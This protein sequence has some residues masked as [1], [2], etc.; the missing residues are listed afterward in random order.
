LEERGLMARRA[1]EARRSRSHSARPAMIHARK[2][3]LG[4]WSQHPTM[5]ATT[6]RMWKAMKSSYAA[7]RRAANDD[8]R[9]RRRGSHATSPVTNL[10]LGRKPL[11]RYP[12]E[13]MVAVRTHTLPA[14]RWSPLSAWVDTPVSA[15]R[16]ELRAASPITRGSWAN[17]ACPIGLR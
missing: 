1:R 12:A 7:R 14:A 11:A 10:Q 2:Y 4:A 3:M 5:V 8:T 16:T 15:E 13:W 6:M 9:S 17:A